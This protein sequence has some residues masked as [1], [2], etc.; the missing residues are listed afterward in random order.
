LTYLREVYV[1]NSKELKAYKI[2]EEIKR[3][4]IQQLKREGADIHH[5]RN[6]QEVLKETT[7]IIYDCRQRLNA[8]WNNLNH[9]VHN[10]T[11]VHNFNDN[12]SED[13]I[14]G[15][16]WMKLTFLLNKQYHSLFINFL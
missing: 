5:I 3:I 6:Q 13:L 14:L 9:L 7:D 8:A 16:S 1:S 2:E 11:L 10:L 4:I 15:S 12:Q